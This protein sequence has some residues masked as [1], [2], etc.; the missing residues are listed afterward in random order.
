VTT[1]DAPAPSPGPAGA[2]PD[3]RADALTGPGLGSLSVASLLASSAER[4]ADRVAV[5]CGEQRTTYAE[6]WD[7][8][9][10]VAGA[11]RATAAV[12]VLG[13]GRVGARARYLNIARGTAQ[14]KPLGR[15]AD[16]RS[17]IGHREAAAAAQHKAVAGQRATA[18]HHG[19]AIDRDVA[20]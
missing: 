5:V 18:L 4:H 6:L 10:A 3:P 15:A 17:P 9:R 13:A 16:E 12:A 14:A 1:T 19:K 8:A 11:L 7:Q 2:W 20:P